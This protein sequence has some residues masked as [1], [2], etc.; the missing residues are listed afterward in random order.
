VSEST[1]KASLTKPIFLC[2]AP[3]LD[4][5]EW[6]R[7]G[8]VAQVDHD[9]WVTYVGAHYP[10]YA[11]DYTFRFYVYDDWRTRTQTLPQRQ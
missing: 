8:N 11:N 6:R 2:L 7:I 5:G 4:C 3:A 1:H 10:V 9:S